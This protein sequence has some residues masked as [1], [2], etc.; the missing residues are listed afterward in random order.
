[1]ENKISLAKVSESTNLISNVF[2]F[3]YYQMRLFILTN[4][5][6]LTSHSPLSPLN[7][8]SH[9]SSLIACFFYEHSL[10]NI[11]RSY[12]IC[13]VHSGMLY[14][15]A[16]ISLFFCS[17]HTILPMRVFALLHKSSCWILTIWRDVYRALLTCNWSAVL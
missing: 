15:Y 17:L 6:L 2:L 12:K 1:M 8:T 11:K 7:I 4:M 5:L 16:L 14:E 10:L 9:L 3:Y 13:R